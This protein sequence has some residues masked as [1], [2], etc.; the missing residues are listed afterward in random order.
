MRINRTFRI[1][2]KTQ[3]AFLNDSF[4]LNKKNGWLRCEVDPKGGARARKSY[5]LTDRGEEVLSLL[6][7]R[8]EELWHEIGE[9]TGN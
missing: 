6:R 1:F 2:F 5:Y 8:V 3:S 9:K 7:G 4:L